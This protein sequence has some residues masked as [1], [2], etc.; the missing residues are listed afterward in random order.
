MIMKNYRYHC[1]ASYQNF[2]ATNL[3]SF[4]IKYHR[5]SSKKANHII[6][7]KWHLEPLHF[8]NRHLQLLSS[9][10]WS[11]DYLM[12][13]RINVWVQRSIRHS[14]LYK[15]QDV[16]EAVGLILAAYKNQLGDWGTGD[17]KEG[18][19]PRKLKPIKTGSW[20]GA[21]ASVVFCFQVSQIILKHSE[22]LY[23]SGETRE[24]GKKI[25]EKE[26]RPFCP[27]CS[28][29]FHS[30][31]FAAQKF[32]SVGSSHLSIFASVVCAFGALPLPPKKITVKSNVRKLFLYVFF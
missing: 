19:S 14:F 31:F 2:L 20:D 25:L 13:V 21:S 5:D 30:V 18:D 11:G 15:A 4:W 23:V 22:E 24:A 9:E 29:P 7:L 12:F 6:T 27:I 1:S 10:F 3:H 28:W 26:I 8:P 16:C 32:L 17:P